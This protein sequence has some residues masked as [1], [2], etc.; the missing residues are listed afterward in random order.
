MRPPI[1]TPKSATSV[2]KS[3]TASGLISESPRFARKNITR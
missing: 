3:A 1:T 2:M